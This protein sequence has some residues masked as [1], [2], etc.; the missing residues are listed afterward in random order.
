MGGGYSIEEQVKR[1]IKLMDRHERMID[2]DIVRMKREKG[3]V[4]AKIKSYAKRGDMD[5]VDTLATEFMLYKINIKKMSKVK[6]RL[7]NIKIKIKMMRS[8]NEI[9]KALVTLTTTMQQMNQ[10]IGS[11][12]LSNIIMDYERELSKTDTNMEMFDDALENDIDEDEQ[13]EIVNSVL[14]EIGVEFKASLQ[15]APVNEEDSKVEQMLEE[16]L[17][18]LLI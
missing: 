12:S 4:E 13:R 8:V 18:S 1:D 2:R 9:N 16:R 6:S 10:K 5:M 11:S 15:S 14:D 3:G 17:K 7:S